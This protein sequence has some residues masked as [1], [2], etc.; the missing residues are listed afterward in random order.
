MTPRDRLMR[1]LD[2]R[3]PD[4]VPIDLGNSATSIHR[5]AYAR[6]KEYFGMEPSEPT[7]IDSMQQV[8]RVE[9]EVLRRFSVDTRQLF[10]RPAKGW[11]RE[12][13]GSCQD[14]WGIRYRPGAGG[15]YYDMYEHPLAEF[16]REDLDRFPWPDPEDP[17]RIAGL[18][19][20]AADLHENSPYGIVLNGFSETI[21]GL[22]SWLRGHAQ[23]YMD[24][25]IN[26]DFLEELLD[27][28]LDYA[29]RLARAALSAVG[30]YVHVIKVADDLGTENGLMISPEHYRKF[31]KPR[32]KRFYE[33]LKENSAAKILI[34]SC[35]A[36]AD[37]IPDLAEIGVD[38]INPVQ[39]SA[40]GM[41]S[42]ELKARFG[43]RI[44]FWG[45]GCDTQRVLPFG[46]VAEVTEEVRRRTHDLAPGGGF[47]F[48][49]VH[50]IQFDIPPEKIA[51]LYEAA[52]R[53]GS[54]SM[55]Q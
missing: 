54:Y 21:F 30:S 12:S 40:R 3:E 44:S 48:T 52:L 10:L 31:I 4:R 35:G 28:M 8:V 27:R 15:N 55:V 18:A 39:V 33:F 26:V 16:S 47:V 17:R 38:A 22:P 1:A 50:N 5:T 13:D 24:F 43:D 51:A 11:R 19:Q 34:H 20:E 23:F 41:D 36:I 45:G 49:P 32:Q 37:I 6:L 7:I 14:E 29:L 53:Y 2:R 46:S 9:E 42:K 25:L